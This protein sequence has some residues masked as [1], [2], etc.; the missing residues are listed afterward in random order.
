MNSNAL[1]QRIKNCNNSGFHNII[2]VY[3][4]CSKHTFAYA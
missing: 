4:I 1:N 2:S 3:G